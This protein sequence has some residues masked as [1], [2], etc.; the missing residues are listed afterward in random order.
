[1]VVGLLQS[2]A[3]VPGI[4]RSGSTIVAGLARG[5]SREAAARYSFLLSIPAIL[6]ATVY[7]VPNANLVPGEATMGYVTG[8]ITAFIVGYAAITL[9]LRCLANERFHLFGYYCLA[10][11]GGV[12]VYVAGTLP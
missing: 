8:F 9:V 2:A 6:G 10:V 11:G 4:S 7:E 3:L 1:M 12:L 5:L